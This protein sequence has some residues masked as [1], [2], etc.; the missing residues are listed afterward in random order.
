MIGNPP[1]VQLQK[2]LDDG[3]NRKFGD[4]YK[5]CDYES[6]ERTGDIYCLFYEKGVRLLK[7]QGLL[8]YIT[9]NKWMRAGYGESIRNFFATKTNP[10]LL[11]DFSGVKIFEA[12]TVDTNILLLS[13]EPNQFQ[14]IC[15]VT[16][17]DNKDSVKNLSVFVQQACTLSKY[18]NS[19]NW[20]ILSP[21]EQNIKAKI[22]SVGIPQIGRAHV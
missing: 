1:Y 7:Q 8:C 11:I 6:F 3:T 9:S 4:L 22:E 2:A 14:T 15:A 12:A 13:K 18:C 16:S 19:E 21:I 5:G 10:K 17:K 20:V